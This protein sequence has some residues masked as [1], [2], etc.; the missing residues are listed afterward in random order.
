ME[1]K[2][3]KDFLSLTIFYFLIWVMISNASV[4][5]NI[6]SECILKTCTLFCMYVLS[7]SVVF[8]SL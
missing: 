4:C 8:E 3:M 6:S 2:P 5:E 1:N 7:R